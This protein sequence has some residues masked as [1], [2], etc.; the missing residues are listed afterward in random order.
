MWRWLSVTLAFALTGCFVSATP[1]ITTATA[2]YPLPNQAL[3]QKYHFL[4]G[5]WHVAESAEMLRVGGEY[6]LRLENGD[7]HFLLKRIDPGKYIAQEQSP[8]AKETRFQYAL[9]VIDG[10]RIAEY[11]FTHSLNERQDD[12]CAALAPAEKRQL[13]IVDTPEGDCSVTSVESLRA[14]FLKLLETAEQ[15]KFVYLV[16]TP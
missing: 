14:V 5:A 1:L 7:E 13:G 6:V 12:E 3:V 4:A 10:P 16:A 11:T 9:L 2:D 8:D 15:P